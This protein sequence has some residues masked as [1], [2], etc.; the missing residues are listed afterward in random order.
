[1]TDNELIA[2][3]MGFYITSEK[4][5]VDGSQSRVWKSNSPPYF[6][7]Y[8]TPHLATFQTSW[9]WLMPVVE[10]VNMMEPSEFNYHVDR[11]TQFRVE[12]GKIQML[13]ISSPMRIVYSAVVDFIKWYNQQSK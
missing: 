6:G 11:M 9:D 13:S 8:R 5:S 10:K 4:P 2:E 12:Q 7:G 3:F 1:M